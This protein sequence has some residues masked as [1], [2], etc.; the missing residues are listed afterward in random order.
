MVGKSPSKIA[1]HPNVIFSFIDE[2]VRQ[3]D[4]RSGRK[5][6]ANWV[7]QFDTFE[8]VVAALR[9]HLG[10]EDQ[11]TLVA[12]L[13]LRHEL[14]T[15]LQGFV[16]RGEKKLVPSFW[17][18]RAAQRVFTS[19][20]GGTT[21]LESK[22]VKQLSLYSVFVCRVRHDVL[23]NA[24]K[25]GTFLETQHGRP[26]MSPVH[27]HLLLLQRDL[28]WLDT[29]SPTTRCEWMFREDDVHVDN[30]ELAPYI[31]RCQRES[32]VVSLCKALLRWTDGHPFDAP[33]LEPTTPFRDMVD[34]IEK[35]TATHSELVQWVNDTK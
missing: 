34:A 4:A 33:Q 16:H 35:E 9:V 5:P 3:E 19:D 27:Q 23:D 28:R 1:T 22:I 25:Q 14:L 8:E 7:S 2:V 10:I 18:A 11:G 30:T 31:A 15:I 26:Q 6:P 12:Q 20:P 17:W 13:N 29:F 32:N 24:I 21:F